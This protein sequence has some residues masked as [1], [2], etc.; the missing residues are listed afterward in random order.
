MQMQILQ[1]IAP[2]DISMLYILNAFS[3]NYMLELKWNCIRSNS[4]FCVFF[5][6]TKKNLHIVSI[7]SFNKMQR[8]SHLCMSAQ[9][10]RLTVDL[11][12][13]YMIYKTTHGS[14]RS[15]ILFAFMRVRIAIM[16]CTTHLNI[17]FNQ[18]QLKRKW[19]S[20]RA[21]MLRKICI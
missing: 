21:Q 14:D 20:W 12:L 6:H 9:H 15:C 19:V 10:P 7:K 5:L 3:Q 17:K 1:T 8:H 16:F 2:R 4:C 11:Y 18:M 13:R